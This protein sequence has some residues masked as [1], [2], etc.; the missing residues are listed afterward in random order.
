[1]NIAYLTSEYPPYKTGGIGT[2]IQNLARELVC[3]GHQ[4]TV[5]GNGEQKTWSDNGVNVRFLGQTKIPQ[6]GWILNRLRMVHEINR[7]VVAEKLDIVEAPDWT[8]L[9]AGMKINCPLVVRCHG[10]DTYFGSL[11]GYRSRLSVYWAEALSLRQA[12]QVVAVSRFAADETCKIFHL[13]RPIGV[14][15]NG[16]D[17]KQ[18]QPHSLNNKENE[19][20]ILY[21]GTLVRKKGVLD[22]AK[23]FSIV[24]SRYPSARLILVGR[25]SA[26][27][28]TKQPSTWELFKQEASEQAVNSTEYVGPQPSNEVV[29]FI[30]RAAI[31]VF[32]SY[33]ETFGLAWVEAMACGKPVVASSIGWAGEI[34]EDGVSGILIHP[35]QHAAYASAIIDLLEHSE[36]RKSMG[37]NARK[38]AE[39]LFSIQR[40]AELSLNWYKDVI[41]AQN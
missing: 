27:R 24:V 30:H 7:I 19:L 11:L 5:L 33:A 29:D 17:L 31:C 6:M 15:P 20:L 35:S 9:S 28:Q 13:S 18:F 39:Q 16:V 36:K 21:F 34:I 1:M 3:Q 23:I 25:D 26:D 12:N 14:I 37:Q 10:S 8:G 22:L 41:D 4:V 40:T 32:P 38:R 2:S